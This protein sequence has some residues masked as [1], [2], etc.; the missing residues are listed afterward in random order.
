[1]IVKLPTFLLTGIKSLNQT[2]ILKKSCFILK[3]LN[4][5]FLQLIWTIQF[6]ICLYHFTFVSSLQVFVS[7][8]Y[9]LFFLFDA[10]VYYLDAFFWWFLTFADIKIKVGNYNFGRVQLISS[11]VDNTVW[12]D[13]FHFWFSHFTFPFFQSGFLSLVWLLDLDPFFIYSFYFSF[14]FYYYL[15]CI[16]VAKGE[17]S[18]DF[19]SDE[20]LKFS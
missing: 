6:Y 9:I 15:I 8:F 11:L 7:F 3:D 20:N 5:V 18:F 17:T 10:Q 12:F 19:T 2:W 14:F 4:N 1:M 16:T 13:L